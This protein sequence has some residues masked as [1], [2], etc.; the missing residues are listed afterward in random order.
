MNDRD[1]GAD[2]PLPDDQLAA[3]GDEC[4]VPYFHTR[5][6]RDGVERSRSAADRQL[7]IVLS[8]FALALRR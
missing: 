6:V 2:W 4:R 1:A 7:E 3:A 8:R 5:N